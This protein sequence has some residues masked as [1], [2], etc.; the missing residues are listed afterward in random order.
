M[1]A[2]FNCYDRAYKIVCADLLNLLNLTIETHQA[3]SNTGEPVSNS[4]HAPCLKRSSGVSLDENAF[5]ICSWCA[6]N[7]FTVKIFVI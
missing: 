4:I 7:T 1:L 3:S 2:L 6:P 5:E